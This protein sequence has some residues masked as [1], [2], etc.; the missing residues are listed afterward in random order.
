M[1]PL[2][3][4]KKWKDSYREHIHQEETQLHNDQHRISQL[5]TMEE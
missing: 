3:L 2:T 1:S 5:E 4:K